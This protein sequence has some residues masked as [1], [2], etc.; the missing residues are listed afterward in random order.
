MRSST[1][2]NLWRSAYESYASLAWLFAALITL[3]TL[4]SQRLPPMLLWAVLIY[5]LAMTLWR[6]LQSLNVWRHRLALEGRKLD[7]ITSDEVHA[8]ML[9]KPGFVWLGW[10]FEWSRVHAQRLYDLERLDV[11]KLRVPLLGLWQQ[12]K[13]PPASKG[14]ALLHGVQPVEHD[15]YIPISDL[16]GHLFVPAT[17]GAIKT[18]L[19]ALLAVQAIRRTPREAVII[20]DPKGDSELRDLIK[21]ECR[22]AGRESDFAHFH[23]A[24]PKDSVRIDPLANWT[25]TTEVASRIAALMPSEN[26][27]DP[28][29]AFAWRVLH[30][31]VA[32]CVITHGRR[33]TLTTIR[34]YV[35]GGIDQLLQSTLVKHFEELGIDWRSAIEPYLRNIARYNRPSATTSNETVALVALYKSEHSTPNSIGPIDGLV[36][37]FEHNRE[38]SQKMLASLIPILTMLTANPLSELL[39]PDRNDANDPRPILN[40]A[41]IVESAAVVYIG[42]DSLSDAVVS[43]AIASICMADL[44]AHAGTRFNLGV[45]EPSIN[46][47]VDEACECV[48]VPFIQLLNKSRSAGYKVVFFSQ[49]FSDFEAKLGSPALARQVLGNANSII[50]GRTKDRVTVEY[51]IE[52]FGNTVLLGTQYQDGTS[53]VS[54]GELLNYSSSYGERQTE[55]VSEIVPPEALGRLPDL[56]YF[57]SFSGSRIVKGRIPLV[58][59]SPPRPETWPPPQRAA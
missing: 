5:A 51:V 3:Q 34:R 2:D 13:P 10:G 42:L 27:N 40:G 55:T 16:Q 15:V 53:T 35:E 37:M 20:L 17:T 29:S 59:S 24:F 47:F 18:R 14:N 23:P 25:R 8:K 49:T 44:T 43:S 22:A 39:S 57:A 41:S 21:A 12:F 28:W 4:S 36:S 6:I 30:L 26:G 33:P 56:E 19:L 11:K 50:A 32:G 31:V 58:K 9:A 46:I 54:G 38:H 7:W 1:P 52:D 48:N 45:R